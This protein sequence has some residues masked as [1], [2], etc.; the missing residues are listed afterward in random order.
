MPW[1][2]HQ[3]MTLM[4][5]GRF[6]HSLICS[7]HSCKRYCTAIAVVAEFID[8]PPHNGIKSSGL[9]FDTHDRNIVYCHTLCPHSRGTHYLPFTEKKEGIIDAAKREHGA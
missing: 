3:S 1:L 4:P 5:A 7:A 8:L 2:A 9:T 6:W